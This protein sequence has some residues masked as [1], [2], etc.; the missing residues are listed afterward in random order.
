MPPV[1]VAF[2]DSTLWQ[3]PMLEEMGV[4]FFAGTPPI[5]RV[6]VSL[7]CCRRGPRHRHFT[8]VASNSPGGRSEQHTRAGELPRCFPGVTRSSIQPQRD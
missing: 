8:P 3:T 5:S 6:G 4:R 7:P 1:Y 2:L